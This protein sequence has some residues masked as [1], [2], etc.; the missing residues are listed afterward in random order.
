MTLIRE[1]APAWRMAGASIAGTAHVAEGGACQDRHRLHVTRKGT[2]IAVVSDGAGSAWLGGEGAALLCEHIVDGLDRH[3]DTAPIAQD[4][5]TLLAACR[6]VQASVA[7]AR[8]TAAASGEPLSAFHATLVGAVV[9]PGIGGLFFHIGDG[10]ALAVAEDGARWL[11]SPP[12]N[13]AYA[14]TTYFF[15]ERD[16]RRHLRFA[17]I[18]PGYETIFVMSDGVTELGLDGTEPAMPFLAPIGNLLAGAS[19]EA[20]EAALIATLDGDAVC[21][22]THDDKTLIWAQLRDAAERAD[23][24]EGL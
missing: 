4:R 22:R 10:A 19:R 7:S 12:H 14:N 1:A 3:F 11:L 20:G 8:A 21:A 6:A 13:G 9:Q 24:M 5:A 16:W 18:P 2:L 17:L 15:T 23:A